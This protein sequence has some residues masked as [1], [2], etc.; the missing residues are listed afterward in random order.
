MCIY[1]FVDPK[2]TVSWIFLLSWGVLEHTP[3]MFL[4]LVWVLSTISF[5]HEM[6]LSFSSRYESAF[7]GLMPNLCFIIFLSFLF[8]LSS[9][10]RYVCLSFTLSNLSSVFSTDFSY[11]HLT[12][13]E[14]YLHFVVL[15][16]K[17]RFVGM[18]NLI[19]VCETVGKDTFLS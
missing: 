15:H 17:T 10:P 3:F 2:F 7:I 14:R 13:C 11:L 4:H 1:I 5:Y 12:L 19:L 8:T 18:I 6:S 16:S 9:F